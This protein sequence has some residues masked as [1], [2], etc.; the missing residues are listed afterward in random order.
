MSILTTDTV[1][2]KIVAT[3]PAQIEALAAK[4]GDLLDRRAAPSDRSLY[5]RLNQ[6]NAGFILECKKASPSKGLIRADFDPVAIGRVYDNYA[7]AISVLT[8][9]QFFQ[10]DFEYLKAVRAAVSIPVLCKD[11]VI[12]PRQLRLARNLG[13]DAALL[14]LSV[15]SD[16]LY[17]ELAAEA[18]LLGLDILTEVSNEAEMARAIA[19]KANII[20]INNRDLRDLSVDLATTERLAPLVPAGTVVISESGIYN[21]QQVRHLAPLV[22]G[23]LVGSSLTE[24]EDI[25]LACR[26]LIYGNNKVCGL[27]RTE[28]VLAVAAAGA[29]YGGL[30]F[31]EKSP[32]R[33]SLSQA[34]ELVT[35]APLNF[36]GVFVNQPVQ[37]IAYVANTLGLHAVQ[38]HG[39]ETA[40]DV[41]RLRQSVQC[42]IWKAVKPDGSNRVSNADRSLYDSA[43]AGQFGGTGESFD[44]SLLGNDRRDALLAGGIGPDN[45]EQA[46]EAGCFG[47]DLNSALEDAPGQKNHTK[48][49]HCFDR[50]RAYGKN[51]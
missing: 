1:L 50:M 2:D 3:K 29:V 51:Q 15:L 33:I 49:R 30:I 11:F 36:V 26:A 38:L 14:M 46:V 40:A 47:L 24:Q 34:R 37:E 27:T 43:K 28:D 20:G 42:Q 10:G 41:D 6:P 44:W 35:A 23:F 7:A 9:E 19:L 17:L 31:A 4:Y 5:E 22:N 18:N 13:A 45:I 21:N 48:L 39:S 16:D 12:D 32:R 25:D 8:D